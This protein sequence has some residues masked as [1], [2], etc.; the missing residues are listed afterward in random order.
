MTKVNNVR[1]CARQG[2]KAYGVTL[3]FPCAPIIEI[4]G[5]LGFDY[6]SLDAEHGPFTPESVEDM[7]RAADAVGLTTL[8]RVPDHE[9]STILRF[10]DRGVLGIT[11]P[12]V[13]NR[14]EAEQVVQAVKYFP[15]GKRG[16]GAHRATTFDITMSRAE[17]VEWAN[18]ETFIM[19]Q[20]EEVEAL[21]N[22]DEILKVEHIDAFTFGPNDLSQSMG[23]PGQATH[24]KVVEAMNRARDKIK[25]ADKHVPSD[26]MRGTAVPGLLISGASQF[27]KE[28]RSQ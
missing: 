18:R 17:Y 6:V 1:E 27:L 9:A 13:N 7:V 20:L 14:E 28:A 19:V 24:P 22:L 12:H 25:A 16:L 21:N 11:V 8:M 23:F 5:Y 26:W 15:L 10:M 4:F 3:P 2:R